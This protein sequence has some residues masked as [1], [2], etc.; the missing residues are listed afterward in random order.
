MKRTA[1][2]LKKYKVTCLE[3]MERSNNKCEVMVD[4]NR[5]ACTSLP[6]TRCGY[7]IHPER[8]S[9]INFLHTETRNG[10]TD[11]WILNPENIILGCAS[12]HIEEEMTG[13]RVQRC[14]YDEITYI[15][16]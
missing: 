15:P 14:E 5:K 10:K 6:K 7:H 13:I 3:V 16:D 1:K 8:V 12:H 11:E 9:Y 2:N 4:I